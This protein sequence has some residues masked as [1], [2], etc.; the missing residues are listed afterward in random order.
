MELQLVK[1]PEK[2][3]RIVES[4]IVR[5]KELISD[6]VAGSASSLS[7]LLG[8]P[9]STVGALV[10]TVSQRFVIPLRQLEPNK[11][12]QTPISWTDET[13]LRLLRLDHGGVCDELS[14]AFQEEDS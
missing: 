9:P 5:G 10:R 2:G 8:N 4:I 14:L 3:A 6:A 11:D 12:E 13:G 1:P 7:A